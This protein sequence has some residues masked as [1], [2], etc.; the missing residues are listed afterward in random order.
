VIAAHLSITALPAEGTSVGHWVRRALDVV[1]ASG[2]KHE[3][4]AMGTELE[5][6]D[7]RELL[8]VVALIDDTLA[9]QG[10]KRIMIQLKID[11]RPDRRRSLEQK[12][13]SVRSAGRSTKRTQSR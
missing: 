10:A 1:E 9:K 3:L 12:V 5:A 8:E 11:D 13:A 4:H 7:L 6:D 2:L